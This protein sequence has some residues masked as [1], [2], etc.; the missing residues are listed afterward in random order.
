MVARLKPQ[1]IYER[2][3]LFLFATLWLARRRGI[4]LV[5]EINDSALVQR[6]RPLHLK[7][8]ARRVEG[9]CLRNSTGLVFISSYFRE[10]AQ[11]AY[12]EIAPSVISPN[13]AD[14][15]RFDPARFDSERLRREPRP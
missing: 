14:L 15:R 11:Q 7:S 10:Q 12:G 6:V 3:S 8:L 9:W 1:L 5:L 13:A 2:Y 4:P